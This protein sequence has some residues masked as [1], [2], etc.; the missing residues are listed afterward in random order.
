MEELGVFPTIF[1]SRHFFLSGVQFFPIKMMNVESFEEHQRRGEVK[2]S[3]SSKILLFLLISQ[4]QLQGKQHSGKRGIYSG[5]MGINRGSKNSSRSNAH[6][7]PMRCEASQGWAGHL[8]SPNTPSRT[9][10][11]SFLLK[12]PHGEP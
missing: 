12:I 10:P 11:T 5:G 8:L 7:R 1:V 2:S 6:N 4:D 9:P 3:D